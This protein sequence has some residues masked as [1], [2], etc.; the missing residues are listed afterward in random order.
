MHIGESRLSL[1]EKGVLFSIE[2]QGSR[3]SR[4]PLT[5]EEL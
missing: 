5:L 3:F 1:S 4:L 2:E